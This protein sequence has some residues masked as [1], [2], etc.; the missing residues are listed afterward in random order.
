[1]YDGAAMRPS[2]PTLVWLYP[3]AFSVPISTLNCHCVSVLWLPGSGTLPG[4][5][6]LAVIWVM[7][8]T[9]LQVV[10]LV[11][12]AGVQRTTTCQPLLSFL[13]CGGARQ[14]EN[15]EKSD[16][17]GSNPAIVGL[18]HI[19]AT[20]PAFENDDCRKNPTPHRLDPWDC[21]KFQARSST[22]T[23]RCA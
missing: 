1:M 13:G 12:S 8:S 11:G 7:T 15:Y 3:P 22:T 19:T 9:P 10:C 23:G 21:F 4:A 5:E 18:F 16:T 17:H 2:T 14:T 20:I 6:A